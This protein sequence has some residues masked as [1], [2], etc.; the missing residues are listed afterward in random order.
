MSFHLF[1]S[2]VV[3]LFPSNTI[4][5]YLLLSIYFL[6]LLSISLYFL[7]LLSI[8]LYFLV[9]LSISFYCYLFPSIT[10]YFHLSIS[11]YFRPCLSFYCYLFPSM[12]RYPTQIAIW[13]NLFLFDVIEK[14]I[15]SSEFGYCI[16]LFKCLYMVCVNHIINCC[17]DM[18]V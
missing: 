4:Y 18:F 10:I 6:V 1:L 11:F 5:C 8:S 7:V 12:Y 15:I 9:L 16:K 14:N 13:L 3:Y 2:I 17:L